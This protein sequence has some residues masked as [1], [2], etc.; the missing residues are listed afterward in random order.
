MK[1]TNAN[2]CI[3]FCVFLVSLHLCLGF[4]K[5]VENEVSLLYSY[6]VDVIL[7]NVL[8]EEIFFPA[9]SLSHGDS[10]V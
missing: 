6:L 4:E 1:T 5:V 9:T 2:V 8:Y 10:I 3:F 7:M